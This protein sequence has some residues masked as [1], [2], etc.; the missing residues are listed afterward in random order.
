[1]NDPLDQFW[2]SVLAAEVPS[3]DE[4]AR[5]EATLRS[6][7]P[8][9][10]LPRERVD[11]MVRA[12]VQPVAAPLRIVRPYKKVMLAAAALMFVSMSIAWIVFKPEWDEGTDAKATLDYVEAVRVAHMPK[13]PEEDKLEAIGIIDDHFAFAIPALQQLCEEITAEP[14]RGQARDIRDRLRALLRD[15]T[16]RAPKQV[17]LRREE[18]IENAL[19]DQLNVDVRKA[20][21]A[22]LGYLCEEGLRAFMTVTLSTQEGRLKL[23]ILKK[24]ITKELGG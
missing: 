4:M 13:Q 3:V 22:H 19:N 15:G 11:A 23:D 17:D 14:I 6:L 9:P 10:R 24:R 16:D 21:L 1:M 18:V 7:E 2:N 5:A 12:A 8:Q 20:A